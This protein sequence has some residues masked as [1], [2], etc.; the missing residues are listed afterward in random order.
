MQVVWLKRDLRLR[1]HAP[2]HAAIARGPVLLLYV[3][4]PSW[5]TAA[6]F[7]PSHLA[8]VEN[9][10]RE[11]QEEVLARGGS[12]A[13]RVGE[14]PAVLASLHAEHGIEGLWSHEETGD[15][16]TYARDRAVRAWA[17]EAGVPWTELP[18]HGVVRRLQDRDGW[19]RRWQARMQEP[20]LPAP[21]VLPAVAGFATDP[22][23]SAHDLGLAPSRRARV[24]RGG[25]S[26][27]HELLASFLARRGARYR[28]DMSSPNAAWDGCSRL[29]T[30]LAYG[31]VGLREI[32]H[33]LEAR[34]RALRAARKAGEPIEAGWLQSLSSFAGR[35][36]WHCH[37]MQKLE[38]EPRLEFENMSRAYDGLRED[39]FDEARFQAW[40]E[41]RTGYP[42]VDAVMRCLDA[43]G[44]INF[45]MRAMI[46]SFASYHLWLDWRPTSV[47]L[48]RRFLDFEPGIHFPQ[49]QM[50][51][52]VTGI[53][54]VRIYSPIKQVH[55]QDP[56]GRFIRAWVPEL[57]GVPNEH[58]AEPHRMPRAL[59]QAVG[60]VIGRDYPAPI[61]DHKT[62][63]AAARER[64]RAIRRAPAT[65]AEAQAVYTRHG[66]RRR[67]QRRRG[68]PS[69]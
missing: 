47:V 28:W 49:C 26:L 20:I 65:R 41:G 57:E 2:L 22:L 12:M 32:H 33:A 39:A 52:G 62:A 11:L 8:F 5:F 15:A 19:S 68:A 10:L 21:P 55:D 23:R 36:R 27:G 48:A 14:V 58:I 60:C 13:L 1:D 17:D 30:H 37:F 66:S 44:W 56:E 38:D 64:M 3:Y 16:R 40:R 29:S 7:D 9:C 6:T 34:R 35:L 31:S 51:S 25:A 24:Q 45:R 42:M 43:T 67:P 69:P 50:Q 54:A 46:V 61:V 63:Y 53:N 59:Q 4:E 18:Q